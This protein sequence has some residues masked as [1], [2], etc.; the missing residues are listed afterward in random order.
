[1]HGSLSCWYAQYHSC[2]MQV[3]SCFMLHLCRV[4]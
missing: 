3:R 4:P 2:G 1:M